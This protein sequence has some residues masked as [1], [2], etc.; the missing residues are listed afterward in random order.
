MAPRKLPR[1][2]AER[3]ENTSLTEDE[4]EEIRQ[5]A[6]EQVE[7]ERKARAEEAFMQQALDDARRADEPTLQ[8]ED[9]F[10]DLPGHAVRILI[11]GV[12]YL[13]GFIYNVNTHQAASMRDIMQR[14]WNHENEVGGANREWYRRPRNTTLNRTH[15]N[16]SSR[17]ILGG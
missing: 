2:F 17:Q 7:K 14:C 5:R 16:L 12:E 3:L 11:D 13:H 8:M 9:V 15:Q 1:A 6:F 4:K 10:I